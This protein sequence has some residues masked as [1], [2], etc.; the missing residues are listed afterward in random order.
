MNFYMK[1]MILLKYLKIYPDI[2]PKI[3]VLNYEN[4]YIERSMR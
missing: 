3:S 4:N 2:D 1:K